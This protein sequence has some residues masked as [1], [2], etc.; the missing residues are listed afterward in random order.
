MITKTFFYL[1]DCDATTVKYGAFADWSPGR[2]A[3]SNSGSST[4]VVAKTAGQGPFGPLSVGDIIAVRT[5][6]TTVERRVVATWTDADTIVVNANIDLSGNSAGY[7]PWEWKKRTLGANAGDAW[8]Q[9]N[10]WFDKVLK[11]DINTLASD[12]V[13]VM[14]QMRG[15]DLDAGS[16]EITANY[17]ATG[18]YEIE[19][20]DDCLALRVGLNAGSDATGTDSINVILQARE[21]RAL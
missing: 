15:P 17:A 20:P 4:D 1:Y 5:D 19:I 2:F 6:E 14:I 12:S 3:I 13:D 16:S 7:I 18:Y 9:A 8:V 11:V 21:Q 10:N